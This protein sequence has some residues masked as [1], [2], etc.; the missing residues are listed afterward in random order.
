MIERARQLAYIAAKGL[1]QHERKL[2][3]VK[4]RGL[5]GHEGTWT[6]PGGSMLMGECGSSLQHILERGLKEALG[7]A[8]KFDVEQ[9]PVEILL[10]PKHNGESYPFV[11]VFFRAHYHGGAI[12]LNGKH[13]EHRWMSSAELGS[14]HLAV[15][16]GLRELAAR[17]L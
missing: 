12:E 3:M 6:L 13:I 16:D 10:R 7:G 2:L 5:Y 11:F 17:H 4:E 15:A 9:D 14:R 1:M 8:A